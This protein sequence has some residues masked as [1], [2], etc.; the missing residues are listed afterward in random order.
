MLGAAARRRRED[1]I[2]LPY[3]IVLYLLQGN[4]RMVFA[5]FILPAVPF[6]AIFAAYA[7]DRVVTGVASVARGPGA[8][9]VR[10][11]V[12]AL[13]AA[14]ALAWPAASSLRADYLLTQTD[15]R[16]QA[17]AWITLHVPPDSRV[18]REWHTPCLVTYDRM[19]A[20]QTGPYYDAELIPRAG[21]GTHP[22]SY[23]RERDVEYLI[24]SSYVY[25][26]PF[27]DVD[28]E[29]VRVEFYRDLG[30]QALLVAAFRPYDDPARPEPAYLSDLAYGP[31]SELFALERPGPIVKVYWLPPSR[32]PSGEQHR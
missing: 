29:R 19:C 26:V 13:L 24:I 12:L 9:W 23:Y 32:P 18:M 14:G 8:A 10:R 7:V 20:G 3:P 15:T 21:L 25:N 31:I 1:W 22:L 11:P 16:D 5:R 17:L 6:L 4:Q 28:R 2:L 27:Y 30:R